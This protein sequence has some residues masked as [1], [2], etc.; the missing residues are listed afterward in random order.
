V[1][2]REH[3]RVLRRRAW[4][5]ALLLL[6]TVVATGAFALLSKPEYTATATVLAK[7][8]SN[9]IDKTLSFQEIAASNNLALKV[10]RQLNLSETVDDL[11]SRTSVTSGRSNLYKV[12]YTADDSEHATS[13]ANAMAKGAAELYQQLGGNTNTSIAN[14]LEGDQATYRSRYLTAAKALVDF[15]HLHPDGVNSKDSNVA[16]QS[17]LLKLDEQAASGAY[18]NFQGDVTKARVDETSNARLF[19]AKVVDDAAAKPNTSGR[20]LKIAYAAALALV[21]GIALIF[22]VEYADNSIRE[23]E[24]VEQLLGTS[25]VGI[26][27]Q[28]NSRTLRAAQGAA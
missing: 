15:N 27:P 1:E 7:S 8:Q 24:E 19:E 14:D 9:G 5:P 3:L 10:R 23:P 20:Y 16:A 28:A 25:V 4:I 12:A 26:I 21:V 11:V 13:V 17:M 6:V 18:T 2:I 22:V